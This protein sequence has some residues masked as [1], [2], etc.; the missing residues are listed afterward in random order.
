MKPEN[1]HSM[2]LSSFC[3]N[4]LF[5]SSVFVS[6]SALSQPKN[7]I[8]DH[9]DVESGLSTNWV[10]DIAQ[11]KQGYIWMGTTDGLNRFDGYS[12]KTYQHSEDDSRSILVNFIRSVHVDNE[13]TL[14]IGYNDGLSRYDADKDAF[15]HYRSNSNNVS[16]I[17]SDKIADITSDSKGN[18]WVATRDK[19]ICQ[20]D[21]ITYKFHSFPNQENSATNSQ[22]VMHCDKKDRLWI[23]TYNAGI[24]VFDIPTKKYLPF[25]NIIKPLEGKFVSSIFEDS[26]GI[27]W[28]GTAKDGLFCYDYKTDQL[29]SIPQINREKLILSICEGEDGKIWIASENLGLFIYSPTDGSVVNLV[30]NKFV[31]TSIGH[32]SINTIMKDNNGNMWMGT[33]ASGADLYKVPNNKFGHFFNNPTN[34]NSLSHNSVLS[35]EEDKDKN[36]WIGTDDGGLNCYNKTTGKF[37]LYTKSS[38]PNSLTSNVILSLYEDSKNNLWVSTYLEGLLM[39]DKKTKSFKL[40]I[41]NMSFGSMLE[42][43]DGNFWLGG[44]RDGVFLYDRNTE[45]YKVFKQIDNDP[46]SISD[47]FVYYVYEDKR[48]NIWACTSVGLNKL[49]DKKTGKF[50]RFMNDPGNPNS[51][52][53]NTVYTCFEDTKGRFWIGTAG[54]LCQMN[55][56]SIKFYTYKEKN[57]LANNNVIGITE[58]DQG[59]LW[60]STYKGISYFDPETK[61]FKNYNKSDGLQSNQFNGRAVLKLSSGELLFG[62]TNGYNRFDPKDIVVNSKAPQVAIKEVFAYDNKNKDKGSIRKG[63]LNPNQDI[64][65]ESSQSNLTFDY[66]AFNYNNT[67]KVKYAYKLEGFD[68]EWTYADKPIPVSYTNLD[69]G[70]YFFKVKAANEDGIWN[71]TGTQIAVTIAPSFWASWWFRSFILIGL[72]VIAYYVY[73]RNYSVVV[74]KQKILEDRVKEKTKQIMEHKEKIDALKLELDNKNTQW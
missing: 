16:S 25:E 66:V 46:T 68:A 49:E 42:D 57:G 48:G 64:N 11:D 52:C 32:N 1:K 61:V 22:Y 70:T 37:E 73:R 5:I 7:M 28:I 17:V 20:L 8:F 53:D 60:I 40:K 29:K 35:F 72:V 24:A 65:L 12:F 67:K 9:F 41:P 59:K 27:I 63:F 34:A 38:K 15:S 18:L 23:G 58:D 36:I 31:P 56:D 33:F 44:W 69:P 55:R 10:R 45:S 74:R 39:M 50:R 54:G 3:K 62:G 13:N 43:K 26:K 14:W 4:V 47:N 30:H 6:F 71:E 19:G 2:T 21:K 51:L